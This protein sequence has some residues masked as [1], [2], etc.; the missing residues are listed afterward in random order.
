MTFDI[1]I[2]AALVCFVS[3]VGVVLIARRIDR[4]DPISALSVLPLRS[5]SEHDDF[6]ALVS[7][8]GIRG[9]VPILCCVCLLSMAVVVFSLL[10]YGVV[11]VSG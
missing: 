6:A 7:R 10:S 5:F 2:V 9:V 4:S 3:R 1:A 8:A 11:S